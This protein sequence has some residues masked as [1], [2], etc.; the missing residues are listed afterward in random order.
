MA[1][2]RMPQRFVVSPTI[3]FSF[4][5]VFFFLKDIRKLYIDTTEVTVEMYCDVM[6]ILFVVESIILYYKVYK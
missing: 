1:E 4:G 6:H 2:L 3:L 5:L